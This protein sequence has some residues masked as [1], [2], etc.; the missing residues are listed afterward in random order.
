MQ[1]ATPEVDRLGYL[2]P[3]FPSQTHTFFWR[4]VQAL[5][6]AG[7]A[8]SV[9]S[10]RRPDASA[11]RHPFAEPARQETHY[12]FPPNP[13]ALGRL[14]LHPLRT[15]RACAYVLGLSESSW[16]KRLRYLGLVPCAADLVGHA[17]RNNY[18]HIHVHSCSDAAHL[19]A[20]A[21]ILGGPSY[22]LTLH[23]DLPVYG[24]DHA[25]KM[26]RAV[27]VGCVT[28]PLQQQV[29]QKV[30]LPLDRA[31]VAWM[32]VN[33]DDYRCDAPRTATGNTLVVVTVARL[34][35]TKGHVYGLA[36]IRAAVDRGCD[37][38]YEIAGEGP[39]RAAIEAEI[40]K[41]GLTDRVTLRG[42]LGE[43]EVL[44]L[45]RRADVFLLPSFGLGEAAPVSVMEA[46]ACEL[47]VVASVIG[48]TP[49]M[50][51][52]GE[53]GLLV[54]QRDVE[55]LTEALVRLAQNP[56]LRLK[57]GRAARARAVAQFD[58]RQT[59]RVLLAAISSHLPAA[60]K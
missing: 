25:S 32:G 60:T 3:E 59:T 43:T 38:T 5:R 50:I 10:T 42:T 17:R 49:D 41:L 21:E 6:Q 30:G 7:V 36:A 39:H 40:Q 24:V 45:L 46:M 22:S 15:L 29:V 8:V 27:L 52:S 16:K 2:V 4:E 1:H 35:P 58:Y 48:G 37:I 13:R 57:L 20:L 28:S 54:P 33:T 12:L 51:T 31:P 44:A 11:C 56:E 34:N 18:R 19:A 53:D 9:V 55:G 14:L 26:K 23:G 47:P